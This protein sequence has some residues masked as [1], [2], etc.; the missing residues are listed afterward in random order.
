MCEKG[1]T[2]ILGRAGDNTQSLDMRYGE[3]TDLE[4]ALDIFGHQTA[5]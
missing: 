4:T 2:F 1:L 5:R 3:R